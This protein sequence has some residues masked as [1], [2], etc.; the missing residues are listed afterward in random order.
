MVTV[1]SQRKWTGEKVAV[2]CV[3]VRPQNVCCFFTSL[4]NLWTT[5]TN[6]YVQ[7]GQLT[8]PGDHEMETLLFEK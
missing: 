3:Y 7:L 6:S 2:F 5:A 1:T 8:D 4:V